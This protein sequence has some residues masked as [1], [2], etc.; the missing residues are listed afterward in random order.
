MTAPR[1]TT[2]RSRPSAPRV[3]ASRRW[4]RCA[5]R[6]SRA[7]SAVREIVTTRRRESQSSATIA[8]TNGAAERYAEIDGVRAE[9]RLDEADREPAEQRHPE[10]AQPADQRRRK[11]GDD[12]ERQGRV[13]ERREQVG[14]HSPAAP[15]ASPE[16]NQ[17]AASTRR[18]GTPSVAVISRS[19]ASARIAV[20][21]FVTRRKIV[22]A[23]GERE[24]ES[25]RD[26]LR[27]ADASCR[28]SRTGGVE[29]GSGRKRAN[30]P[31][32]GAR[33]AIIPSR[34]SARPSVP[35]IFTSGSRAREGG[36]EHH[37]VGKVDDPAEQRRRSRTRASRDSPCG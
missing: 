32:T 27:Q 23:G 30:A 4:C 36:A 25:E 29:L 17:A 19:L 8:S 7:Q 10:R 13:V 9:H 18:T 26:D 16:P 1:T 35:I 34:I 20:P 21:S 3:G 5:A 11:R 14:E 6:C 31:P 15:Q 12:E 22:D 2:P 28:R 37:A 33:H 24:R